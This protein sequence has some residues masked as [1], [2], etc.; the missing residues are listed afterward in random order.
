MIPAHMLASQH[1]MT[2]MIARLMGVQFSFLDL[3]AY[4]VG[5]GC[6][7]LVDSRHRKGEEES[8]A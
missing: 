3:L 5:I 4:A 6:V 2:R 7:Y 8:A 1:W